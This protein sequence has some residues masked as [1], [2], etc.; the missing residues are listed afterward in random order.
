MNILEA[1]KTGL[2]EIRSHKLRSFLS[3][4]AIAFGVAAILYTFASVHGMYEE[5]RRAFELAGPGRLKI[6]RNWEQAESGKRGLSPGL[7]LSDAAAL[8]AALPGLHMLYPVR[9]ARADFRCGALAQNV[10][11]R[12]VTPEWRKRDWV[13]RLRGRLLSDDD[14]ARAARVCVLVAPAASPGPSSAYA[15]LLRRVDLLGRSVRLGG[16]P[17]TVVGVL[18]SPPLDDDPRWFTGQDTGDALLVPVSAAQRYLARGEQGESAKEAIDGIELDTGDAATLPAARR[19][20][21]AVLRA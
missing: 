11:V 19:R 10:A 15:G 17:F 6:G 3:F 21:E 5:Q 2:A 4:S 13:Y 14:V 20:I 18:Q 7:T 8:R 12:G 1:A 16:Q 9:E